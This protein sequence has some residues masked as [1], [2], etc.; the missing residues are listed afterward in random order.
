MTVETATKKVEEFLGATACSTKQEITKIAK[1]KLPIALPISLLRCSGLN[2]YGAGIFPSSLIWIK[3]GVRLSQNIASELIK[4]FP[5]N[6][7][8]KIKPALGQIFSI[9]KGNGYMLI[10]II[11]AARSYIFHITPLKYPLNNE[12]GFGIIIQLRKINIPK[13]TGMK[14][15]FFFYGHYIK[16]R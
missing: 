4:G 6:R 13:N 3:S 5:Y 9:Q 7:A 14:L 1:I 12:V 8:G 16:D 10:T 2:K 11:S 15:R